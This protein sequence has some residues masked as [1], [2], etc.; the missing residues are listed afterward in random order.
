M[1]TSKAKLRNQTRLRRNGTLAVTRTALKSENF[2]DIWWMGRLL[3]CAG[4]HPTVAGQ[5]CFPPAPTYCVCNTKSDTS[6]SAAPPTTTEVFYTGARKRN[7]IGPPEYSLATPALPFDEVLRLALQNTNQ[8][9]R[10]TAAYTRWFRLEFG[11]CVRWYPTFRMRRFWMHSAA[12]T[13]SPTSDSSIIFT[14][15]FVRYA[16]AK[17]VLCNALAAVGKQHCRP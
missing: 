9:R 17:C 2:T 10:Q 6:G 12:N 7:Q 13:R 1:P 16:T 14:P 11:V 15:S 4:R 8:R 3:T 5:W